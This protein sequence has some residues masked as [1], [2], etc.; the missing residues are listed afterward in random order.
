MVRL[1]RANFV[2]GLRTDRSLGTKTPVTSELVPPA[3]CP[4]LS[5]P[6]VFLWVRWCAAGTTA[7]RGA[8][9]E[10]PDSAPTHLLVCPIHRQVGC[11]KPIA[12]WE[13]EEGGLRRCRMEWNSERPRKKNAKEDWGPGQGRRRLATIQSITTSEAPGVVASGPRSIRP[14]TGSRGWRG[15]L[16]D[17]ASADVG[18][19]LQ[20]RLRQIDGRLARA[21]EEALGRIKQ[22][23]YGICEACRHPIPKVRLNAVPWTRLCRECKEQQST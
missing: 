14:G 20:I 1:E 12:L 17:Q 5:G 7:P 2:G 8:V 18:A 10:L 23:T 9:G 22:G 13:W 15:D 21:I 3:H 16:M 11:A 6:A 19:E 4:A